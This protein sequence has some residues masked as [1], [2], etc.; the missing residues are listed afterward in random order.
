MTWKTLQT[1]DSM[2]ELTF[3]L[4][5]RKCFPIFISLLT[6]FFVDS[7]KDLLNRRSFILLVEKDIKY[8]LITNWKYR[9]NDYTCNDG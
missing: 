6:N 9:S 7:K 5:I 2:L 1:L 3:C 4:E 8:F